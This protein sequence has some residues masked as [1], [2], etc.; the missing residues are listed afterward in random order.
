VYKY[1]LAKNEAEILEGKLIEKMED[2]IRSGRFNR[3]EDNYRELFVGTDKKD[4]EPLV[5]QLKAGELSIESQT[6]EIFYPI[7]STYHRPP[8]ETISALLE[9]GFKLK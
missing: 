3:P 7:Q 6:A 5:Q 8:M 1:S 9:K 4:R 2:E